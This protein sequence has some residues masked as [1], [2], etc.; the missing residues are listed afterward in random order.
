V[1]TIVL[2]IAA[3]LAGLVDAVVGGGGLIQIP[4]LFTVFP[5]MTPA[6]LFGTNKVA[7]IFGTANATLR[8][9]RAIRVPWRAALP[10]AL[11]AFVCSYGGAMTVSLLPKALLRPVML[12]LLVGVAIYTWLRKDFGSIDENRP[13][14]RRETLVAVLLGAAIGFYDG[15]FGPGAGSFL[16]FLFVRFFGLDFLRASG[17]AKVVNVATN[18][19]ALL[20]FLP[21]GNFLAAT[22]GLMAVANVAGSQL[23]ARLAI[24]HG[25]GFVRRVFLFVVTALIGKFGYDTLL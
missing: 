18:A 8:Y 11:A 24:R 20:Y 3:G 2:I 7:S 1:D 16:I 6:T 12:V 15:F 4:T 19:A 9:V 22:A 13:H 25:S 14:G 5:E 21:N 10:A 17:A 23:G